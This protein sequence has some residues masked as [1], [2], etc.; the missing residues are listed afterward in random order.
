M[1]TTTR[2]SGGG[3]RRATRVLAATI[4]IA[5]AAALAVLIPASAQAATAPT[6][7]TGTNA[8][9]QQVIT[10]R[11]YPGSPN[12]E[13][14]LV[15]AEMQRMY[16][17]RAISSAARWSG[18]NTAV[19]FRLKI[20]NSFTLVLVA[21]QAPYTVQ[22]L[23]SLAPSSFVQ[24]PDHSYLLSEDVFVAAGA[25]LQLSNPDGMHIHLQSN[26]SG[27]TSIVTEQGNLQVV[28]SAK[29]PVVLDA[30]D[31][32]TGKVDTDTSD[33]RSYVS[34]NG[35][36]ATFK[37][38]SFRNL[39][40]WS[41]VTGG[42]TLSR[43]KMS[44]ADMLV[45]RGNSAGAG[46]TPLQNFGATL[47]PAGVPNTP[48]NS[49]VDPSSTGGYSYVSALIQHSSFV[50][51]A[52]GLFLTGADGVTISNSS[53]RDSLIDGLVLHRY[54]TNS[55]ISS[56][57][58]TGNAID[59]VDM[60]RASTGIVFNEVTANENG[61]NGITINGTPLA[62]GPNATGTP[63]NTYGNNTVTDSTA[64][65]NA[66]Y[67]IEVMG[68]QNVRITGNEVRGDLSGI[69]VTNAATNVTIRN[70]TIDTM[71]KNGISMIT[72]STGITVA[73]NVITKA[74]IGVYG[75]NASATIARNKLS[76]IS[77]HGV[78][79]LG[80]A[81]GALVENNTIAGRGPSAVDIGRA[82]GAKQTFNTVDQWVSTKPLLV[83]IR[84]IFQP[85]TVMWLILLLVVLIAAI[86]GIR[87]RRRGAVRAHPY[88]A[89][90]PLSSYTKGVVDPET[91]G[92]PPAPYRLAER[93]AAQEPAPTES[94]VVPAAMSD[95]A[96][97]GSERDT[98]REAAQPSPVGLRFDDGPAGAIPA[99]GV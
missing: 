82:Q 5:T 57:T 84:S 2:A 69:V 8:A 31:P 62:S 46:K 34:V 23:L 65:D 3:A 90:A 71:Q 70:N 1:T 77:L 99:M 91:L 37:Y 96:A 58:S 10:G 78:V 35:G 76:G 9:G 85:L 63:V 81:Q 89:L 93:A 33:G 79:L 68:G 28:G 32:Q 40:F 67:G 86:G 95:A 36:L 44:A 19:P 41:G 88:A 64:N 45:A 50:G 72:N 12:K 49:S 51:N 80:T 25:T 59:G 73:D 56:V 66:R 47:L 92:L 54:V 53:I 30:W 98:E 4:A 87:R 39:G 60:T 74:R 75:R 61:R 43:T 7:V 11:P 52:Y 55:T 20:G 17:I 16:S 6:P 24:M 48:A 15:D 27:F 18:A 29:A 42:V 22:D 14:K 97:N 83:T 38:A 94:A 13:A 21:R 26:P